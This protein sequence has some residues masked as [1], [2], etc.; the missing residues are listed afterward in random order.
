MDTI[1][2][3]KNR[4]QKILCWNVRG[5]NSVNKWTTIKSKIQETS[6]DIICLQET[7]REFFDL[8]FIK[9]FCPWHMIALNTFPPRVPLVASSPFGKAQ[10]LMA[11]TSSKINFP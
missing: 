10:D 8:A 11:T 1:N 7:K 9:N 4:N 3:H 6:C 5:I 2:I